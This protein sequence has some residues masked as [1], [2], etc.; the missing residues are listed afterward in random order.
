MTTSPGSSVITCDSAESSLGKW[1]EPVSRRTV[2]H[3]LSVESGFEDAGYLDRA[4]HRLSRCKD[5]SAQ[6]CLRFP[7]R[8]I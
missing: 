1:E 3:H 6:R 4:I 8:V 2:L 5:P 7:P